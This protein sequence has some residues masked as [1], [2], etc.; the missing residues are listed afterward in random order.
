MLLFRITYRAGFAD[1][2]DFHLSRIGHF[3]LDF[4]GNLSAQAFR[5]LV[6]YL[7]CTY[8]DA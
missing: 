7:V 2:R 1:D 4:L 3:I 5:L 8:D 6:V